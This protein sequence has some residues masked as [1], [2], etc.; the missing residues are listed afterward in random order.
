MLGKIIPGHL[1]QLVPFLADNIEKQYGRLCK[2]F[3]ERE[4][5]ASTALRLLTIDVNDKENHL[6]TNRMSLRTA[7]SNLLKEVSV[8]L[9]S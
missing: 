2:M 6:E 4:V 5:L 1:W 8:S 9:E 3:I 7:T